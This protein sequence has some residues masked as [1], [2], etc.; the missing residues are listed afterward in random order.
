MILRGNPAGRDATYRAVMHVDA[1][2]GSTK[3]M[4]GSQTIPIDFDGYMGM[5][6]RDKGNL[7]RGRWSLSAWSG[8]RKMAEWKFTV[9]EP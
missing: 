8:D 5:T 4:T 2:D 3:D 7:K 1:D 9:V 6:L